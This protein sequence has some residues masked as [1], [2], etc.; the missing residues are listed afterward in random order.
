ME[1]RTDARRARLGDNG[2]RELAQAAVVQGTSPRELLLAEKLLVLLKE[3]ARYRTLY[4]CVKGALEATRPPEGW[5]GRLAEYP[6]DILAC[7]YSWLFTLV[8]EA[9]ADYRPRR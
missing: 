5:R 9:L 6:N 7:P 1:Q 2:A 8:D 3:Q 4:E